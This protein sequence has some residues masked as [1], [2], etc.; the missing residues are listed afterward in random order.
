VTTD[1]TSAGRPRKRISVAEM[2]AIIAYADLHKDADAAKRFRVA[3][4]TIQRYRKD[5]REGRAPELAELV[6]QAKAKAAAKHGD[7]L[8]EAL[9]L[10]LKRIT[11]LLPKAS[12]KEAL[13]AVQVL[14]DLKIQRD[15]F[16]NEGSKAGSARSAASKAEG[17][18]SSDA[19][20]PPA[21]GGVH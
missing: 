8:D 17:G 6:A 16:G 7:L 20:K 4:K 2:A 18:A 13:E 15:V 21:E 1:K 11:K 10:A 3:A 19:S 9:E 12:M 14:G 5:I